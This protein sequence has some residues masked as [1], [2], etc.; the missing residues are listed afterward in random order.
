MEEIVFLM[1]IAGRKKE[2]ALLSMLLDVGAPL[3]NTVYG[4]GTVKAGYLASVLGFVPE[5]NKTV[6]TCLLSDTKARVIEEKLIE[7][8]GFDKPNTGVAFTI[9]IERLS[10]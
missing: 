8:F 5:E 4:K 2:D 9:P 7:Q 1:V 10:F 6:I 3:I